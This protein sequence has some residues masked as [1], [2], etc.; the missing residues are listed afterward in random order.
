MAQQKKKVNI[1]TVRNK[2]R[3]GNKEGKSEQ[4]RGNPFLLFPPL[5]DSIPNIIRGQ[6]IF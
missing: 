2:I 6:H 3:G 1:K 5:L 4:K